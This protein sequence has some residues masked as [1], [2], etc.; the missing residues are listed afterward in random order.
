[1]VD[2]VALVSPLALLGGALASAP[3]PARRW[4][5]SRELA[6]VSAVV[7]TVGASAVLAITLGFLPGPTELRLILSPWSTA[8]FRASPS[9]YVDAT[10]A[11]CVLLISGSVLV[12]VL[13]GAESDKATALS[14][15]L[16][17]AAAGALFVSAASTPLGLVFGWVAIDLAIF[18][19]ARGGRRALIAGQ[20]GLLM[21]IAGL[22]ALSFDTPGG[23]AA[24]SLTSVPA[25]SRIWLAGA[26]AMRMGL[27]PLWWA[28]PR[29]HGKSL[30]MSCGTRMAPTIAG[31]FMFLRLAEGTGL[32]Q[33]LNTRSLAPAL[34]AIVVGALLA[35]LS[36]NQ[37]ESHDWKT[38][39]HASLVVMAASL[40]GSLGRG[41]AVL[42]LLDLVLTRTAI[43]A[44]DGITERGLV[45]FSRWVIGAAA[46]A[47]PPTLGFAGRWLLYR[48]I[49]TIRL[50]GVL[51]LLFVS[52][53][54]ATAALLKAHR[55]RAPEKRKGIAAAA[56]VASLAVL[57]LVAGIWSGLLDPL[58]L[59]VAGQTLPSALA[60]MWNTVTSP[61]TM[62][63]GVVLVC[64]ILLPAVVAFALWRSPRT[65]G[66][67]R[68]R[69]LRRAL[70]LTIVVEGAASALVRSGEIAQ[71]STG[72]LESRRAMA[73][74]LMAVLVTG[75]AVVV[76]ARSG[77]GGPH[78]PSVAALVLYVVA[79]LLSV[80]L[81]LRSSP[82]A[83][84]GA[85]GASYVVAAAV[86]LS[87]GTPP[88][89]VATKVVVGVLVVAILGVS[90][91]QVLGES[92]RRDTARALMVRV[93]PPGG[94]DVSTPGVAAALGAG[95][96][97]VI[98]I[99][100]AAVAL[101][102]PDALLQ[103]AL[104]LIVGGVVTAVFARSPLRLAGGVLFALVGAEMVSTG[105]DAGL[106]ISGGLATF[107]L[108]FAVV[109]A[110]Y[111]GDPSARGE[112][113]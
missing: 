38:T 47:L 28:V 97:S 84:I 55:I 20:V 46:V 23:G 22:V 45:R 56:A 102:V 78:T 103:P 69:N 81:V 12:G 89:V 44:L 100:S 41:I 6:L 88:V 105:L 106:V 85:L 3:L 58:L 75:G 98:G 107:Q 91:A 26:A 96:I 7:A 50:Y 60:D 21:A 79:A 62:V 9:V 104:A 108:L 65:L 74:T 59:E 10:A 113:V 42:L 111:V 90:V 31:L 92:G 4:R 19:G 73:W 43:Y 25:A 101:L 63:D 57:E 5:P 110:Y 17:V 109:A 33:G 1:M 54:L 35:W 80:L 94:G 11:L 53:A 27:Y 61:L 15:P 40:G 66:L 77:V 99:H 34:L 76:A 93:N 82:A 70:R 72:L 64:A 8:S 30:W 14:G 95:L 39:Y 71:R 24:P 29:S 51:G 52:S 2:L 48:E 16:A 68:R 13:R 112:G 49:Y 67:A 86:L 87:L 37:A 83:T 36:S 18:F 32:G